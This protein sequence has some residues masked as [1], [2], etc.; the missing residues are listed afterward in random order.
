MRKKATHG[1]IDIRVS[2]FKI[3]IYFHVYKIHS[4]FYTTSRFVKL[5]PFYVTSANSYSFM[6]LNANS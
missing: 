4:I 2:R 1:W 6:L 3:C 5:V